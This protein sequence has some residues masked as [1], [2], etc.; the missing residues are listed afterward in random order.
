M[1]FSRSDGAG[2]GDPP[3]G[4]SGWALALVTLTLFTDM[5]VYD[6]VVP[7]LPDYARPWG[8]GEPELGLLFGA[9]ALALLLTVPLAGR[10]CDRL[11]AGR[12]LR[13]GALGLFLSLVLYAG[14]NGHALLFAARAL[15]GAA[16]GTAWTAGLALLA[17]A[18][19]AERR[20][21]MLGT[22]M[23]GMSLGTLVGP[24]V[25]GLLFDWGGP[26]WPFIAA[27]GWT[28]LLLTALAKLPSLPPREP[29]AAAGGGARPGWRGYLRTAGAVVIGSALLSGL[30]PTLP[31]DLETRLGV[32]PSAIGA[33]FGL[34]ALAYGASAPLAGWAADRWG[35]RRVM[36]AGL[37]ACALTLPPVALPRTAAGEAAALAAFGV[38]CAFLLSPTLP[39]IAA[40]CERHGANAFGA[41]YAV[42]NLAYAVGMAAGPVA[43]GVLAPALGFGGMLGLFSLLAVAYLP[44]LLARVAKPEEPTALAPPERR[45][46]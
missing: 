19:P 3:A 25:G 2:R 41:A 32:G 20:G 13:L 30:E 14:A 42:F 6:M 29:R 17:A 12:A 39:E 26:R 5:A 4:T 35:G 36:A 34:A 22:A 10:L 15:Q 33:L 8:V 43:G 1:G 44:A 38:A 11:G 23:A 16:G 27:A 28:A 46:A 31:L 24:P 45:A 7:F 21:R 37:L 18:F 40:A 9:Y